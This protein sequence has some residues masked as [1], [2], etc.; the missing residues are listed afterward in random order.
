MLESDRMS[1]TLLEL[2]SLSRY[3][4]VR[5]RGRVFSKPKTLRA[6]DGVSVQLRAGETLGLVGESGCGKSTTAR[7][8]LGLIPPTHGQV[9]YKDQPV[10]VRRDARWKALR[11]EMQMVYQD[12]LSALDRRLSVMEQVKEPLVVFARGTPSERT[13]RATG[14]LNEVGLNKPLWPRYPHELSGGQRQRVVLPRA[15]IL[16]PSLLVC[17]EPIS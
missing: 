1:E 8:S 17:D 13:E 7:M 15:L 5:S 16:E 11:K 12:P 2:R 6:V 14:V 9:L 3:Y 4:R 10:P